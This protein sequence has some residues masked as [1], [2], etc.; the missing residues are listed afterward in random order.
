MK[1]CRLSPLTS[2]VQGPV[3]V[4]LQAAGSVVFP[5]PCVLAAPA[6]PVLPAVELV[7]PPAA[8][9]PPAAFVP[10]ALAAPAL[11]VT[12]PVEF[13]LLELVPLQAAVNETNPRIAR[14][15]FRFVMNA[16][17]IRIS[18]TDTH[19]CAPRS[20]RSLGRG[21]DSYGS[22]LQEE[23]GDFRTG[24]A[25]NRVT[26]TRHRAPDDGIVTGRTHVVDGASRDPVRHRYRLRVCC[27]AAVVQDE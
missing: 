10:P 6:T 26:F 19:M 15:V 7:L 20:Q 8:D 23:F 4:V 9:A 22:K 5:Q 17:F 21:L 16:S 1:Y 13:V 11:P 24:P 3:A 14:P 18:K 2:I 25:G 12:P 27:V